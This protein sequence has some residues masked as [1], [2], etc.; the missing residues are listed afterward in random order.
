MSTWSYWRMPVRRCVRGVTKPAWTPTNR[1]ELLV[2]TLGHR[3]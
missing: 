1:L 2:Q 3:L